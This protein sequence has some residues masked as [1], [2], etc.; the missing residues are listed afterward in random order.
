MRMRLPMHA[1][2]LDDNFGFI[3][4]VPLLGLFHISHFSVVCIRN[5]LITHNGSYYERLLPQ[6]RCF[7]VPE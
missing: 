5:F 4:F 7:R 1:F 2:N 6:P 3:D